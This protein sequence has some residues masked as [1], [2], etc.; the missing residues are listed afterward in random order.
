MGWRDLPLRRLLE[1]ELDLPVYTDNDANAAALGERYFGAAQYVDNFVYVVAN[2]GLGTGLVIGGH[3]YQGA[4]GFAGE[5][6]HTT[7]DPDGPLCRCGNRGC[8]ERLASQRALI[9]RVE[10]AVLAGQP[11]LIEGMAKGDQPRITVQMITDAARRGDGVSLRALEETG[12][13]LGIGIAN[14]VN[15]F[16]PSLVVFG[17]TLSLAHEFLIPV[18]RRVVLERAMKGPREAARIVVSAFKADACV[19]G[20]VALVLH[21]ILIRPHLDLMPPAPKGPIPLLQELQPSG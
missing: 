8:W 10:E 6:G 16:N 5:A 11:S 1:D 19:M 3:L 7:I 18:A 4:S 17:G 20:G 14:L 2:I 21:D 15:M 13:Y 9:E 12:I